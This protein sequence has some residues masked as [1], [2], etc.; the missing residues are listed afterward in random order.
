LITADVR[1]QL[2]RW[3][4]AKGFTLPPNRYF[5]GYHHQLLTALEQA[6]PP[7]V[8]VRSLD[9]DVLMDGM[10]AII[11]RRTA[12]LPIV[13]FDRVVSPTANGHLTVDY[14]PTREA[15][16]N[17]AT[18]GWEDDYVDSHRPGTKSLAEQVAQIVAAIAPRQHVALVDDGCFEGKTVAKCAEL[19]AVHGVQVNCAV[20]GVYRVP[21]E[22]RPFSFPI[23]GHLNYLN[24]D[25]YDWVCERDFLLGIPDGGRV[26]AGDHGSQFV[27]K[28]VCAP[29]L[30]GFGQAVSWGSIPEAAVPAFTRAMV[31]LT[32]SIFDDIGRANGRPVRAKDVDRWP[33]YHGRPLSADPNEPF[34][35]ILPDIICPAGSPL[36]G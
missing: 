22:F 4:Q 2:T 3:A 6:M 31:E 26:V 19:L 32:R 27:G 28:Q 25:L 7:D 36:R 24:G 11:A 21:K 12:D 13:M 16:Y 18:E 10:R 1:H 15:V 5:R 30:G 23:Y 29:Y 20:V 33:F 17:R 8:E 9:A 34:A 14:S 35:D